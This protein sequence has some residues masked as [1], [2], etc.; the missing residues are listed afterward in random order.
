MSLF[1]RSYVKLYDVM[2]CTYLRSYSPRVNCSITY[3]NSPN[4]Y[5]MNSGWQATRGK[6]TVS[7]HQERWRGLRYAVIGARTIASIW[8]ELQHYESIVDWLKP[9]AQ[10]KIPRTL[11]SLGMRMREIL[12][13]C[14]FFYLD[15]RNLLPSYFNTYYMYNCHLLNFT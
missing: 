8:H 11:C 10:W 15:L 14:N 5:H 2:F 12:G 1:L 13:P 9:T 3:L 6:S 7:R 4:M